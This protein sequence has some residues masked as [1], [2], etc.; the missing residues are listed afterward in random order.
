MELSIIHKVAQ[1]I[2]SHKV[3]TALGIKKS[4]PAKT[5]GDSV[6]ISET[7]SEF[8][9][10][11]AYVDA[12]PEREPERQEKLDKIKASIELKQYRLSEDMANI[13]AERI[14]RSLI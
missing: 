6:D 10:T 13:I 1:I 2:A 8:R 9:A 11:K 12:L 14:A 3:D 5:G 4:L 7:G